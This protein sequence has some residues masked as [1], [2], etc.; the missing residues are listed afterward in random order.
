MTSSSLK[1]V[2]VSADARRSELL[3]ALLVEESDYDVV[4]V[5]SISSAYSRIRQLEPDI[6]IVF[7]EID[8]VNACQLLSMLEIDR[9][10]S[11]IRVMTCATGPVLAMNEIQLPPRRSCVRTTRP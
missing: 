11:G 10:L 7:M 3:D 2:A 1:V 9:A 4:V 5:E 6:V 8:D